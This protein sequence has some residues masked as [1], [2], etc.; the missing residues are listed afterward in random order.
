MSTPSPVPSATVMLIRNHATALE[1]F[2]V[3]R[4]HQIDFASGAL[5]FPGGKVDESDSDPR[6]KQLV[7]GADEDETRRSVQVGAIREVFEECGILIACAKGEERLLS[8][9]RLQALDHHR[10]EIHQGRLHFADFLLQNDLVLA[11][12]QLRLFAHWITPKMMSKRF[13]TYFYL[14]KAPEGQI[15]KHDEQE[16]VDSTWITPAQAVAEAKSGKRTLMFPT[17][18]NIIRLGQS[19]DTQTAFAR[20]EQIPLVTVEPWTEKREDGTYLCI[21]PAAGYDISEEKM[22]PRPQK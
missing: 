10:G 9:K 7:R 11:T 13:D 8:G 20:A 6:F 3:V 16:S 18:R 4:H 1:V 15:A 14:V 17:M 21:D 12:D 2:M 19:R 22:A 5:V